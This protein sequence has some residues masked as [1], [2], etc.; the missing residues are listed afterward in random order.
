MPNSFVTH[1]TVE[2]RMRLSAAVTA[3]EDIKVAALKTFIAAAQAADI[4]GCMGPNGRLRRLKWAD[5]VKHIAIV[6]AESIPIPDAVCA[7]ATRKY[8]EL[9]LESEDW[10]LQVPRLHPRCRLTRRPYSPLTRRTNCP[11]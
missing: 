3:K 2:V 4:L 5:I 6:D 7:V 1:P 10:W 9:L 8:A 11:S